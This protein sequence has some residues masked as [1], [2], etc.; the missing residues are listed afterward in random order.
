MENFSR[1]K[2]T[3]IMQYGLLFERYQ[4]IKWLGTKTAIVI[5]LRKANI[6]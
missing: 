2:Y 4:N 1:H 5:Q 3:I 6:V